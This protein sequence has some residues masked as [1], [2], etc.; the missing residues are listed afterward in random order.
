MVTAA[1]RMIMP[2]SS[3]V[4]GMET[5][6]PGRYVASMTS[7]NSV[8]ATIEARRPGLRPAKQHLLL[9]FCQGH[10]IAHFD[11]PL[12]PEALYATDRGTTL[13][14]ASGE[15][16]LIDTERDLNTISY[17]ITRYSALSPSDL[18]T[19]VQASTP[20]Q[21]ARKSTSTPR[22]EWAWLRDWFRRPDE[23]DDPDDERPR[24]AEIAEAEAYLASRR[25][26]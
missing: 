26:H 25:R 16:P 21:L 1:L 9:F 2:T 6:A 4:K 7:A 23:T 10:H 17:V 15:A 19:L 5:T 20:W 12:F 8:I 11:D 13:E 3:P 18:R 14:D 24:R 22:I